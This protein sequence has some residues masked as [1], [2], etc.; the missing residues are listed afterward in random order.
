MRDNQTPG[1]AIRKK[2]LDC[3]GSASAVRD[4]Q[5]DKLC[6]GPCPFFPYREGKGRPSVKLIRKYCLWC[7]GG[8]PKLVK[9]CRSLTCPLYDY[10]MATNPKRAGVRRQFPTRID[11][12]AAGNGKVRVEDNLIQITS[13]T[14]SHEGESAA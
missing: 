7:T 2:C 14:G 12:R 11:E 8:S 9:E 6:D 10:R 3:A 13:R 4:C 5:G 1:N